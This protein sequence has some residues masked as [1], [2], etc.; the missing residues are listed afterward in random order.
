VS[1]REKRKIET[2]KTSLPTCKTIMFGFSSSHK[3]D[4]D[5]MK[6]VIIR[7][8]GKYIDV[9]IH[10]DA[11]LL[12]LY[13]MCYYAI[14]PDMKNTDFQAGNRAFSRMNEN[15][16]IHGIFVSD[17]KMEDVLLI[18]V[19]KFITIS[20]FM[21]CNQKFFNNNKMVYKIFVVDS[22]TLREEREKRE[23]R[24]HPFYNKTAST[25]SSIGNYISNKMSEVYRCAVKK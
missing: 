16:V 3:S 10:K 18:P 14:C 25:I 19:H 21:K 12:N 2:T 22:K 7:T 4:C 8:T 15:L 11:S 5:S 23:Q 13:E 20:D 1:L 24:E 9:S 6:F 17:E